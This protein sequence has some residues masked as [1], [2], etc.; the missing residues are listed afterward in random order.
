[1][2]SNLLVFN[3]HFLANTLPMYVV[4]DHMFSDIN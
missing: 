4:V 1:M 3:T 2:Y